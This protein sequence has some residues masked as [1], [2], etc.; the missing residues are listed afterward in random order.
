VTD[1]AL[2]LY[3]RSMSSLTSSSGFFLLKDRSRI[4]SCTASQSFVIVRSYS[5][6]DLETR[7]IFRRP[8]WYL[9]RCASSRVPKVSLA[10]ALWKLVMVIEGHQSCTKAKDGEWKARYHDAFCG[11]SRVIGIVG[12]RLQSAKIAQG[13]LSLQ[14]ESANRALV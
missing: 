5:D 4:S 7:C 10:S 2:N 12:C 11:L 8:K 13:G 3:L 1:D 9:A 6:E 14:H